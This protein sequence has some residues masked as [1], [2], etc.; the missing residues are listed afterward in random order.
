MREANC[1]MRSVYRCAPRLA[2]S[3]LIPALQPLSRNP[4]SRGL[5]ATQHSVRP[6]ADASTA[7]EVSKMIEDVRH[8]M[9]LGQGNLLRITDGR[10]LLV[11]V[12]RGELWITEENEHRDIVL[13]GGE[14]F[15]LERDG[16]ALI[17]ALT[18]CEL[19]MSA[20]PSREQPEPPARFG[21]V[22]SA[23]AGPA[24]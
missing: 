1:L 11:Q 13:R 17:Y 22:P 7:Y 9:T 6:A 3:A 10:G 5:S 24:T 14:S 23:Q 16:V 20:A 19:T 8:A 21:L 12:T 4:E 18:P 2:Q 15:R